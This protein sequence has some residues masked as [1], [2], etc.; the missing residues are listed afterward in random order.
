MTDSGDGGGHGH[1]GG[2]GGQPTDPYAQPTDPYGRPQE[3]YGPPGG[4]TGASAYP[5]GYGDQPPTGGQ[6]AYGPPQGFPPGAYAP[7]HPKATTSLVLGILGVVL[8]GIAAPFA[9]RM[10][11]RTMQEI[12]ASNGQL[13]GRGS[14]QAGYVLGLIGTILLGIALVLLV[15]L[16]GVAIIGTVATSSS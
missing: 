10:G 3:P 1:G 9:W 2:D 14:A 11:K 16:L 12:D 6:P 7:D 13:G 5:A 8:C 15:L 4:S